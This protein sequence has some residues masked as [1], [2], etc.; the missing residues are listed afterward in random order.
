M[1]TTWTN[2]AI[3]NNLLREGVK[4]SGSTISYGFPASAPSWS[5]STGEGSG[6]STL[7]TAQKDMARLALSLWD[8]LMAPDFVETTSSAQITFQNSST[9]VSYAHAY[10]PTGYVASGSV[11][12]NP[13][14]N[15]T[16]GTND[17]VTPQIGKWGALAYVH[18]I[19]HALGLDHPGDYNGG[20]P[21][22]AVDAAYAQD[23]IMY[24]VMSY[25]GASN[26]GADWVASDGKTYYAQTP[27]LHDVLAIQALYGVETQTRTGDTRY[28]FNA[29]AGN[30]IFDFTQ[31]K[32]PIMTLWDAGG[33]DWLDLSGFATAS[34]VDLSQGAFSD[35]DG[36]TSNIAIAFGCDIENAA[37]G[38]ANDSITGNALNNTLVGNAGNDILRGGAGADILIGGDGNDT[39]YADEYDVLT[40]FLGG[41]GY[42][43]LYFTGTLTTTFSYS[44]YGF[45]EMWIEGATTPPPP[46]PPA[47]GIINGTAGAETLTGTDSAETINGF[48][49]NDILNG[50]GGNDILLGGSGNDA[51]NGGAGTDTASYSD[52]TAGVTVSLASSSSQNTG[53]SGYDT[54]NSIEN[55]TGSG[56]ADKLTGSSAANTLSGLAGDDS[57]NGGAG[58]DTM[59]GGSGNDTYTVDNVGDVADE[60][61]GSGV[62]TVSSS[63][64]FSLANAVTSKG[65]IENLTLTGSGNVNAT[66][67]TLNNV[68]SGN[69]GRNTLDGGAGTDT[70]SYSTA[71]YGVTV[72]LALSTSQY[73]GQASGYD[74]LF[75]FENLTG[76]KNSDKLTGSTGNNV[77]EGLSGNDTLSGGSGLDTLIGGTGRDQMTGG[78][79]SDTFVFLSTAD[80]VRGSS[81]DLIT[82]FAD[83]VDK[84]NLSAIDA[85]TGGTDSAFTLIGNRAFTGVAGEL[86]ALISNGQTL[87]MG[88][89]NG[90]KVADFQITLS[91]VH[92]LSAGDFIL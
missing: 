89:I 43:I 11:W 22:Y 76:S 9:N 17:L 56:L 23:T 31:N 70:A 75:N 54:L 82:D 69:S 73:T 50:N 78:S 91:G 44:D 7:T 26:T 58:A 55:L 27:M 20:S 61:D 14:Y 48:A 68:I 32:H 47:S 81:S 66:G 42:D 79:Q 83:G 12:F 13:A 5:F 88:D 86:Q 1:P 46:P 10:L 85:V 60:T 39:F 57:L 65:A 51:V 3:V 62:D 6:F 53:G 49:G 45:E 21:T 90:D 15:S 52:A 92:A 36:M 4:W 71:A 38:T 30:A 8:D 2:T 19:G 18:E 63:V 40:L 59:L 25:F 64:A 29:N 33:I 67:N 41:A 16:Q 24:S 80:S 35:C 74:T 37:G 77:L 84:F 87:V 72:S 34:R 28:G